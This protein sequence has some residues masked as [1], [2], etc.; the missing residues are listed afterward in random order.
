M[1]TYQKNPDSY[2]GEEPEEFTEW[3]AR[4]EVIAVANSW[5]D[6]NKLKIMPACL[7]QYAFQVYSGLENGEKDTYEH[8]VAAMEQKL[9]TKEKKMVWL[10]FKLGTS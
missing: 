3:K 2:S 7:T 10:G 4:F 6:A 8:L 9:V 5:D 1:A